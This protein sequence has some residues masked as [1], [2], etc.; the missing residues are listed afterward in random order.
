MVRAVPAAPA[1]AIEGVVVEVVMRPVTQPV[2]V[3]RPVEHEDDIVVVVGT[4]DRGAGHLYDPHV[5][6]VVM[7]YGAAREQQDRR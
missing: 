2:A 4:V 1:P 6:T 5:A 3:P 7:V